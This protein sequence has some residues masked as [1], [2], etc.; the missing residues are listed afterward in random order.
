MGEVHATDAASHFA[1]LSISFTIPSAYLSKSAAAGGI[2]MVTSIG[3]LGGVVGP[4]FQGWAKTHYGSMDVGLYFAAIM[5]FLGAMLFLIGVPAKV[6][7][8][9]KI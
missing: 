3:A 1:A 5:V 9:K 4:A 2:A 6:L 8:G 7:A